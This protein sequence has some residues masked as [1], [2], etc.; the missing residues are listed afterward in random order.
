MFDILKCID[1]VFRE[2]DLNNHFI[3]KKKIMKH[4]DKD[5]AWV[6]IDNTIYSI[7]KDDELLLKVFQNYYGKNVR[8]YILHD[9]KF[10]NN[11]FRI[12]ILNKLKERKV[13]STLN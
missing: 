6:L 10:K 8:E 3:D 2:N 1:S 7:R 13:G 11:K 4:R 9:E 12:I 5:N